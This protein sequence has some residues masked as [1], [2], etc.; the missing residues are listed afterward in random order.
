MLPELDAEGNLPA[1]IH[2]ASL[3]EVVQRFGTRGEAREGFGRLLTDV[4][5]AA[6]LYPTIKRVLVWGSFVSAK[7]E[8]R[9]LDYSVVVSVDHRGSLVAAE[10]RRFLVPVDARA[11]YGIDKGYFAIP[12]YPL[13]HYQSRLEFMLQRRDG[14][15]RGIVEISLRGEDGYQ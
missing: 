12:D 3:A 2:A 5:N 14:G 1:A 11:Y 9:D 13:E 15:A 6:K 7:A 4:V 10:H 8:P